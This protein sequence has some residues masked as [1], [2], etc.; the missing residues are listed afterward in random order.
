MKRPYKIKENSRLRLGGKEHLPGETVYL[1]QK[2]IYK[3]WRCLEFTDFREIEEMRAK[4]SE[5]YHGS[6]QRIL[7]QA[8]DDR[9]F[10]RENLEHHGLL[11][12]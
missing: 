6:R 5:E 2:E 3:Y 12:G 9:G 1:T 10:P 11:H 8:M 7:E 4:V